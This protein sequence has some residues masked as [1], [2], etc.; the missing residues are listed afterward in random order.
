VKSTPARDGVKIVRAAVQKIEDGVG[1]LAVFVAARQVNMDRPLLLEQQRIER[2]GRADL[3]FG[4]LRLFSE[5]RQH[6]QRAKPNHDRF[7]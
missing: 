7:F 5:Q 6:E 4:I 3:Y 1:V 2:F